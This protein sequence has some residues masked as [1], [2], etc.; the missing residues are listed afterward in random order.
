MTLGAVLDHMQCTRSTI[1]SWTTALAQKAS[2]RAVKLADLRDNCDLLRIPE[3]TDRD[4]A[5]IE[6]YQRA[7]QLINRLVAQSK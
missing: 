4:L 3:P 7:I 1:S 6:K 5:R 2:G